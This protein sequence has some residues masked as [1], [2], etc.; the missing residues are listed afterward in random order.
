M[1]QYTVT[2]CLRA[3]A[4]VYIA[5]LATFLGSTSRSSGEFRKGQMVVCGLNI[6]DNLTL[7]S[8]IATILIDAEDSK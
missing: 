8:H 5:L 4:S 6:H 3:Y 2:P 7:I 1:L